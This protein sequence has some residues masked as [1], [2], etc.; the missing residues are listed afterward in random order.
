MKICLSESTN[1]NFKLFRLQIYYVHPEHFSIVA[2]KSWNS[3]RP[4][5]HNTSDWQNIP[6]NEQLSAL[7]DTIEKH[8]RDQEISLILVQFQ[9]NI[10]SSDAITESPNQL[11][12]PDERFFE[13]RNLRLTPTATRHVERSRRSTN[14]VHVASKAAVECSDLE[15][16]FAFGDTP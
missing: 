1:Y 10:Y 2:V 13:P 15:R 9:I 12:L 11:K 14:E 6:S 7:L 3:N 16:E 4:F 5:R 8:S